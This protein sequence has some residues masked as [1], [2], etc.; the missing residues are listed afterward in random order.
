MYG[1]AIHLL[2]VNRH[3]LIVGIEAGP[4]GNGPTFHGSAQFKP[5]VVMQA[6]CPMFLDDKR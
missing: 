3:A 5:E 4:F 6:A 1:S 2:D